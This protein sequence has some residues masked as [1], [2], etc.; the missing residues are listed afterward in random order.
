MLTYTLRIACFPSLPSILPFLEP[1]TSGKSATWTIE[2][3]KRLKSYAIIWFVGRQ[4]NQEQAIDADRGFESAVIVAS[5]GNVLQRY[6]TSPFPCD[7]RASEGGSSS[8]HI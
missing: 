1:L 3:A 2:V 5:D 8:G 6:G 4:N 7:S